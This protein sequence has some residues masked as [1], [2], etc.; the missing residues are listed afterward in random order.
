MSL[1][2]EKVVREYLPNVVHLSLA[3]SK[4]NRPWVCEVHFAY[5]DSLNLYFRSLHSR[6]HSQE[7][8]EN[9]QVAGNIVR[10][11]QLG[12]APTGVYFEGKAA[13]IPPGNDQA[14]AFQCLKARIGVGDEAIEEAKHEDG[15]K[16]YKISVENWYIFGD[17]DGKGSNKYH[18]AWNSPKN[19]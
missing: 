13:L 4:N 9:P 19:E 12:E 11:H 7:I 2:V 17:F 16:F 6:R 8:A 15:H 14:I 3:T 1:D 18:L 5:D 10:Q